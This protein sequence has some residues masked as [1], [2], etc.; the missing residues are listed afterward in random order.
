M[1]YKFTEPHVKKLFE[2]TAT[3]KVHFLANRLMI[4]VLEDLSTEAMPLEYYVS[5]FKELQSYIVNLIKKIM[6]R[7]KHIGKRDIEDTL[8][9][10]LIQ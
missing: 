3:R 6:L 2:H 10:K 7:D 9:E 1:L 8:F 5:T 4:T